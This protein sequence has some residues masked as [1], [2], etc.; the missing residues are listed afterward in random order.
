MK[1]YTM[2]LVD[3]DS[4]DSNEGLRF[5]KPTFMKVIE[6]DYFKD[7]LRRKMLIGGMSHRC[8]DE[9]LRYSEEHYCSVGNHAD[10]LVDKGLACNV[11]IKVWEEN[12][13]FYG[14]LLTL[15]TEKGE[16]FDKLYELG[17][18]FK[19]SMSVGVDQDDKFYYLDRIL[20]VDFTFGPAFKTKCVA[21]EEYN[22]KTN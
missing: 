14:K 21:V 11:L 12:N 5:H 20:G 8:R 3:F 6:S 17:L 13:K 15:P 9:F 19:V 18:D 2:E 7:Q 16:E 1:L 4:T 22:G 10:F